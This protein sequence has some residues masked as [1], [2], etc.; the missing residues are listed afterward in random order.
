MPLYNYRCQSAPGS[1][2]ILDDFLQKKN[3]ITDL[4][5]SVF[6]HAKVR[7]YP[8]R[9]WQIKER[10]IAEFGAKIIST[11]KSMDEDISNSKII[12][13]SYPQTTFSEAMHSGVPTILL[14]LEQYWEVQSEFSELIEVCKKAKII[15]TDAASA[16][17]HV[18][19][20]N[21]NPGLWWNDDKTL[22]ARNMF[23]N[24]CGTLGGNPLLVWKK[25]FQHVLDDD[26]KYRKF[27]TSE[28]YS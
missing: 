17:K 4:D 2:L 28:D 6:G 24:V 26:H 9:G 23:F 15:H 21:S 11:F 22:F 16:A 20:I 13:C 12:I 5:D 8:D 14:Y 3:F 1:S 10:Y 19:N 18:N 7:P 25:F 27:N